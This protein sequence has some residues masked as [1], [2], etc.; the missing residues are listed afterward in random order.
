MKSEHP[1]Q[2][3][4]R[5]FGEADVRI[6]RL[7]VELSGNPKDPALFL[8]TLLLSNIATQQRHICLDLQMISERP[9]VDL[10]GDGP[11]EEELSALN[12]T[13]PSFSN[14]VESLRKAST[15]GNPG[16]Y[17]PLILDDEGR[18]YFYRYWSYEQNLA[19]SIRQRLGLQYLDLPASLGDSFKRLFSGSEDS[20]GW[21]KV[22]AF[23][24]LVGRFCVI[25]GGPGTGKTYTVAS[26]IAL[27]Q[28]QNPDIKISICAPTG[29]AAARL[30]E[31][32]DRTMTGLKAE[33][34]G[35][36]HSGFEAT[37]IHRLLGV[38]R[39]SI[40]F[41]HHRSNPL[42]TDM[43]I[44][45]EAS[46]VSLALMSKL[47]EALP[48]ET[49]IVLLGDKNQ[50]SSVE[51]GSVLGDIC[52]AGEM[53]SFSSGF[54][55]DYQ[56]VTGEQNLQIIAESSGEKKCSLSDHV[57]ALK[58]SYRFEKSSGIGE[59][60]DA[61]NQGN[62]TKVLEIFNRES[63]EMISR[64]VLPVTSQLM[65]R[66]E[67]VVISH[68]LEAFDSD[69]LENA[70]RIHD[71][72][73]I[74]C[75]HRLGQLGVAH[76]NGVIEEILSHQGVIADNNR[77]YRGRLIII[78]QNDYALGLYNGDT[79]LVWPDDSGQLKV[80]FKEGE[81]GFRSITP[82]RL[83]RHES[84]YALTIHEAQG[85]EFDEVLIILKESASSILSRELLY[86]AVTRAKKRIQLW[87]GE[88]TLS[89]TVGSVIERRSGLKDKLTAP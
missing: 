58:H 65:P 3:S 88:Q 32:I 27:L 72:F 59:L 57:V 68:F 79:G 28:E 87:A 4:N 60:S 39:E 64:E 81:G 55:R 86:T 43:V 29:K 84:A 76:F 11:D 53:E 12:G 20:R 89:L 19:E 52:E 33:K 17:K 51:A 61:I 2:A 78:K 13:T 69:S 15:V 6:A 21:Q 42:V 23:T 44:V 67:K 41:V 25:S 49:R 24:A 73:K 54:I 10:V 83:P 26:I 8:A 36:G 47:M 45:D 5:F 74:L 63:T 82:A 66:M 40:R 56:R 30:Q 9:L 71:G 50:L 62:G 34:T 14:W 48:L 46:M 85:S 7:M 22:A 1:N 80:F 16:E 37:T 77:F 31:S 70:Y 18:L 75:S 38:T 35:S